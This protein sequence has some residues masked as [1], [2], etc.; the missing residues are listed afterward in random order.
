MT[1]YF[2]KNIVEIKNEYTDFLTNMMAPLIYEGI[3]SLYYLAKKKHNAQQ[4]AAQQNSNQEIEPILKIFKNILKSVPT[5]SN[6]NIERE[7]VRIRDNSKNADIFDNL[8]R[9]CFKSFIVLLTYNSSGKK[10]K[11]VNERLHETIDIKLFIHKCYIECAKQF[12]NYPEIF[13]DDYPPLEL[14]RNERDAIEII[15]KSIIE[16]IRKSLPMKQIIEEY[17]IHDYIVEHDTDERKLAKIKSMLDA[18]EYNVFDNSSNNKQNAFDDNSFN[19][20]NNIIPQNINFKAIDSGSDSISDSNNNLSDSNK[21]NLD[22]LEE[23]VHDL[24]KL[25]FEREKTT[26]DI[27]VDKPLSHPKSEYHKTEMKSEIKKETNEYNEYNDNKIENSDDE[28]KKKMSSGEYI[29]DLNNLKNKKPMKIKQYNN[30]EDI[31]IVK[32]KIENE[33]NIG[34]TREDRE[35][36]FG[37]VLNK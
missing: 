34:T 22:K 17:L 33:K 28:L 37:A 13:L 9:S 36:Y 35:A 15:K 32:D 24:S 3:Q 26:D 8:V 6:V 4:L 10:C 29:T 7:M 19:N 18:E 1:H 11:L 31:N 20:T 27:K 21:N 14:Q 16:G 30:K 12:Y 25:I 5:I 23:S 2:E